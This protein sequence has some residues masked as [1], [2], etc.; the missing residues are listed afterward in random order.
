M[1]AGLIVYD[2]DTNILNPMTGSMVDVNGINIGSNGNGS[3]QLTN[4]NILKNQTANSIIIGDDAG[5]NL[6]TTDGTRTTGFAGGSA[7]RMGWRF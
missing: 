2:I 5:L 6:A 4:Y 1:P 7:V 3:F